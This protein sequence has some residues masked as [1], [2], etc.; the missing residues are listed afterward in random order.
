MH[1]Q[2]RRW[3]EVKVQFADIWE[4]TFRVIDDIKESVRAAALGLAKSLRSLS[5][6]IM[7]VQ[8]SS[9][10]EAGAAVA[11]ALPF[12]VQKGAGYARPC[13]G[14][15]KG[16]EGLER[17]EPMS[18][19]CRTVRQERQSIHKLLSSD[20]TAVPDSLGLAT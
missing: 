20:D 19:Q 1:V 12:L 2:G 16:S 14:K 6:R 15:S 7:D 5:L 11:V 13:L 8:Q 18:S 17:E 9:P 10:S 4:M 3:G